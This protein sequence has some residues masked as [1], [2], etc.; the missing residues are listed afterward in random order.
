MATCPRRSRRP[1]FGGIRAGHLSRAGPF[2]ERIL[3]WHTA[4]WHGCCRSGPDGRALHGLGAGGLR[5][6][7]GAGLVDGQAGAPAAPSPPARG[8]AGAGGQAVGAGRGL[9]R[10]VAGLLHARV[11]VP[12][13][14]RAL[15]AAPRRAPR[16]GRRPALRR[17]QRAPAQR[18]GRP[19]PAQAH[20]LRAELRHQ[21]CSSSSSPR[22]TS[23]TGSPGGPAS[24]PRCP[25]RC[26]PPPMRWPGWR[27]GWPRSAGGARPAGP[28]PPQS[29][30]ACSAR[31][32][33]SR[34]SS[35]PNAYSF[36]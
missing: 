35:S 8:G 13:L 25:T 21:P 19:G 28:E 9:R 36:P 2:P 16:Q 5:R 1:S 4:G 26:R 17:R 15:P 7:D 10:D 29:A 11:A 18:P 33:P 30:A 20:V 6:Q 23:P 24:P 34:I 22:T 14:P 31:S 12:G 3:R 27:R 32:R